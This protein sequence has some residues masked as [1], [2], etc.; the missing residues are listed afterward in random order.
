MKPQK[1]VK[2]PQ[3]SL[4]DRIFDTVFS[5]ESALVLAPVISSFILGSPWYCGLALAA[6]V[7]IVYAGLTCLFNLA[8]PA[9]LRL[10]VRECAVRPLSCFLLSVCILLPASC[11]P[12]DEVG[13][14]SKRK[15]R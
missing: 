1:P 14:P 7:W 5:C 9:R 6:L 11:V 8:L 10:S 15:N 13:K 3:N 2:N 12:L 4:G